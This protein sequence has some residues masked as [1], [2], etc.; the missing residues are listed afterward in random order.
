MALYNICS[1][2]SLKYLYMK[3]EKQVYPIL[4]KSSRRIL[5]ILIKAIVSGLKEAWYF[6]EHFFRHVISTQL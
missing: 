3:K 6:A 1:R 5:E 2:H 4:G